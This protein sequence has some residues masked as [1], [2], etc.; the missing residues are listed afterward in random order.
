M[1]WTVIQGDSRTAIPDEEY[2][3]VITSPPYN[4]GADYDDHEDT[5]S[6]HGWRALITTVLGEA[7][8]RLMEG[9]RLCVNVQH[10]VGRSPMEPV[11]F[12]VEGIGHNLPDARYRGAIIW[13]KGPTNVTSWGS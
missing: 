10:G 9:G 4:V 13:H 12:H 5:M 7:W 11:A 6:L 3:L 2:A 1:N 8:D